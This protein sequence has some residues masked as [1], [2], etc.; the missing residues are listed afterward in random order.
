MT[1]IR[2]GRWSEPAWPG[3]Y[4]ELFLEHVLDTGTARLLSAPP[5]APDG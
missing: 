3:G 5:F 2:L 1:P 4:R